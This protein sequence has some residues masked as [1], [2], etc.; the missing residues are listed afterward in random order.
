MHFSVGTGLERDVANPQET[1]IPHTWP[2]TDW[3]TFSAKLP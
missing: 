1:E 3:L 2:L